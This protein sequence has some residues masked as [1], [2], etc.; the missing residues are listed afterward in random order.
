VPRVFTR[1]ISIP[2]RDY[3]LK[4]PERRAHM[5]DYLER[6]ALIT[7]LVP[8]LFFAGIQRLVIDA[9]ARVPPQLDNQWFLLMGGAFVICMICAGVVLGLHFRR[10]A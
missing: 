2:R 5:L 6:H 9:N 8:P 3:W 4:T 10:T 1:F 7:G